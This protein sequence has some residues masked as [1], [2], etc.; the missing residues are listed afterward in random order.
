MVASTYLSG[1][2]L[3]VLARHNTLFQYFLLMVPASEQGMGFTITL[4]SPGH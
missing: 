2:I 3:G 1:R 4:D